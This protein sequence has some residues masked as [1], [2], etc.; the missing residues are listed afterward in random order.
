[1]H[2]CMH[3]GLISF[4]YFPYPTSR[5]WTIEIAHTHILYISAYIICTLIYTLQPALLHLLLTARLFIAQ[6]IDWSLIPVIQ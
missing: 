4:V 3:Q 2:I 1:M 6:S 5:N